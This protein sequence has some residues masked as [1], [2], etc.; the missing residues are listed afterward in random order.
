MPRFILSTA[1][2]YYY[3][4]PL[5]FELATEA[6]FSGVELMVTRRL[7]TQDEETVSELARRWLP[8][9]GVHGPFLLANKSVWG[10]YREKIRRSI[11][12]ARA[13]DTDTVVVHL[14]YFWHP[15]Y[16]RWMRN[17]LNEE[18]RRAGV[19]LA[20]ENAIHLKLKRRW[21]FSYYNSVE[22]LRQFDHIT[23][24]TS[25]FAITRVDI[26]TAWEALRDKVAHVHLSDNHGHGLDDHAL[27]DTGSLPL[28]RFLTRLS[29]DGYEGSISLELN[30]RALESEKPERVLGHLQR[31][32]EYCREHFG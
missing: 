15:G 3:P 6:G 28:D 25:H 20:V 12:M 5:V 11:S 19:K 26:I 29:E 32:L 24:D 21:N 22:A 14:P 23:M 18:G 31:S 1:S 30:P 2:L 16:A 27:P 10:D 4:L 9:Q 8:V 7:E 17:E 13:L